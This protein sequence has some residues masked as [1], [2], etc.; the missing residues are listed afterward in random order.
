M[1]VASGASATTTVAPFTGKTIKSSVTVV[2]SCAGAVTAHKGTWSLTTGM[3]LWA[4]ATNA[5]SCGAPFP[6]YY[7]EAE[8]QSEFV[9]AIKLTV[10]SGAHSV[11]ANFTAAWV[12]SGSITS[13]GTCPTTTYKSSTYNYTTGFCEAVAEV[14]LFAYAEILDATNHSIIRSTSG[15]FGDAVAVFNYSENY[16]SIYWYCSVGGSCTGSNYSYQSPSTTFGSSG[17]IASSAWVN[18]TFVAG[19]HYYLVTDIVGFAFSYTYGLFGHS[20][21]KASMNAGTLGNGVTL[22]S[23]YVA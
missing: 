19:H 1:V 15:N 13:T 22:K 5:K 21:A 20:I 18:G 4:G 6:T 2:A 8:L 10:P 7:S 3:F 16:T 14:E 12:D 11:A 9:S 23:I 17:S